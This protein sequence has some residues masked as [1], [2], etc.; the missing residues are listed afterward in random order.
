MIPATRPDRKSGRLLWA[1]ADGTLRHLPRER[2]TD[3]FGDGDV[4]VVN[5]AATLPASLHGHHERTCMDIEMRLAGWPVSV[6]W[7]IRERRFS[8]VAF[9]AG[10]HRMATED[11]PSPPPFEPGDRLVLGPLTAEVTRLCGHP[12]LL[13]LR[14]DQPAPVLFSG[15]ARHGKPV[16]YAHVPEPLALWDA[17]TSIAARPVSFEPPSAGFALSW[18]LLDTWRRRGVVVAGVTHAAGLSS[19]GDAVLDRRLPLDEPYVIPERTAAA[20]NAGLAAGRRVIAIG[21]TVV[22]ALEAS[23]AGWRMVSAGTGMARNRIGPATG[24]SVVDA[25]L[26]GM[27]APGESHF[28]ILETFASRPCLAR[29]TK[30]ARDRAYRCHEFGDSLLI[31]KQAAPAQMLPRQRHPQADAIFAAGAGMAGPPQPA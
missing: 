22:R 14:F 1:R 9:G 31:E 5:D 25:L 2:L 11:R 29:I 24:T 4:V 20:V 18:R 17:W 13:E 8:A 6:E 16:Q 3:V 7:A 21:T 27:H 30:S 23:A 10:D 15:L 19:T 26:T 28:E 12:R